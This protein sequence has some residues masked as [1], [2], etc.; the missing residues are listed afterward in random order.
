MKAP[1]H[2]DM[3]IAFTLDAP[4]IWPCPSCQNGVLTVK[5][6][7][8]HNNEMPEPGCHPYI[9]MRSH[10]SKYTFSCMFACTNPHCKETVSCAGVGTIDE[11]PAT[12]ENDSCF[13]FFY[14]PMYFVPHLRLIE[15]PEGCPKSV[16]APLNE[17]FKLFFCSPIAA[18]NNVRMALDAL[19]IELKVRRF[20]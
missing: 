3:E 16:S 7:W 1:L 4:T 18:S 6:D 10:Y 20:D 5:R 19:L 11:A 17:S 13:R 14:T 15:I 9:A 12:D 2:R 8:F